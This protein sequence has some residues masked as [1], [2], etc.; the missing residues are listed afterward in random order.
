M[1]K[2]KPLISCAVTTQLNCAF[3]FEYAKMQFSDGVT[4]KM[5]TIVAVLWFINFSVHITSKV[6]LPLACMKADLLSGHRLLHIH[7]YIRF[8]IS[9][10]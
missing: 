8:T 7:I 9:M 1:K 5:N 2:S 3:V 4:E 6:L 10:L